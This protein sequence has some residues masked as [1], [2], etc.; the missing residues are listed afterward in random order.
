MPAET[1]IT[2]K[3][4]K[5]AE[6]ILLNEDESFK[7]DKNER[8]DFIRNLETIDLHAV[9]GSGKTTALLAKLLIL[10]RKLPFEDGSG[11]LVIS[12]T[13]NAVDEIKNE[14]GEYC[15][16]LF[17]YPNFIGTIQSF[18]NQYL[19]KPFFNQVTKEKI[20]KIN[21]DFYNERVENYYNN[22]LRDNFWLNKRAN[23]LDFLQNIRFDE[24]N[25]LISGI[26]S[27]TDDFALKNTSGKTY[28]KLSKM[29]NILLNQGIL[30]YDDAYYLANRYLIKYPQIK[31]LIQKRFSYVFV[32]EMQDMDIHQHNI[33][34]KIFYNN[35]NSKSIYQR[36]GD[37]N[38]AIYSGGTNFKLEEIWKSRENTLKIT[39]SYRFSK[40]IADVLQNF[41]LNSTDIKSIKLENTEIKPHLLIYNDDN[42]QCQVVQ[43]FI[44]II[45]ELK[46]DDKIP[47][48]YKYPIKAVSWITK[49]KEDN[50]NTLPDYCPK[51]NKNKSTSKTEYTSLESYLINSKNNYKEIYNNLLNLL[52][53]ILR[54]ENVINIDNDRYYTK[55]SLFWYLKKN[56]KEQYE[57][58][59]LKL[60]DWSTKI[61]KGKNSEVCEDIKDYLD[62]FLG[63]FG[64]EK[65]K[66]IEFINRVPKKIIV[67]EKNN[68]DCHLCKINNKKIELGSVH[69]VK[70]ETH[71]ATLYLESFYQKDGS[72]ENAKSYESQRLN[73]QFKNEKITDSDNKRTKKS[74]RIAYVGFSR[75]THLLA[76]AVHQ[77]RYEKYLFDINKDVW[78]VIEV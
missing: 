56:N 62:G 54:I 33:L 52:L 75:P 59:K 26:N 15:A 55:R 13:N 21:D 34:E 72:G 58:L 4:I 68:F 27:K 53:K 69:S 40:N 43:R 39:G 18:V 32:D 74:A 16:K 60:Y 20:S 36:I 2:D 50:K 35:G 23:T 5:Y 9:P 70:G 37:R 8:I 3:D 30:C 67:E 76:F 25:M 57:K 42:Y 14:I 38:Q 17:S 11:I 66:S 46:L 12:H 31:N 44:K 61:I 24:N 63:V 10:E 48:D 28:R 64:I 47:A 49:K 22:V 77:D 19:A 73:K 65:N 7:D 78:E 1:N 51:F 41:A 29:K 71:T 6:S 45:N